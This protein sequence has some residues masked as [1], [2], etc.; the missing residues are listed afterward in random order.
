MFSHIGRADGLP[1]MDKQFG[2]WPSFL[3]IVNTT[4]TP[5]DKIG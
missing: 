5:R 3:L 1:M 4:N 2:A